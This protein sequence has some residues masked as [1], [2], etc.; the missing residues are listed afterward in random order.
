MTAIYDFI[1]T[2]QLVA[3]QVTSSSIMGIHI[4]VSYMTHT[5]FRI[6]GLITKG[7]LVL[8]I[9]KSLL[10]SCAIRIEAAHEH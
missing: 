7:R 10:L 4:T 8:N 5:K 6:M 1:A 2:V 9:A 3:Y